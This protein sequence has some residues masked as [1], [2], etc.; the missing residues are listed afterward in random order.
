M[1]PAAPASPTD[2]RRGTDHT[3]VA[4]VDVTNTAPR[5]GDEVVQLYLHQRHGRAARPV[6]ELK[7]FRRITLQPGETR[8]VPFPLGPDELRY[9]HPLERDW[10]ID[11]AVFDLWVGTDSTAPLTTTFEITGAS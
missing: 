8:T 9:W 7:G 1:I 6:R 5:P 2:R 4:S 11:P 3:L 10:L